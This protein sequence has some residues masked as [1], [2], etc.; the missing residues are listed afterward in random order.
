MTFRGKRV[1][2]CEVVKKWVELERIRNIQSRPSQGIVG[3]CSCKCSRRLVYEEVVD[4]AA[5]VWFTER[6]AARR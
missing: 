6:T 2:S 1:R 3:S 5:G 4:S